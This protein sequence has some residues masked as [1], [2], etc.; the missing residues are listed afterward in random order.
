MN[1]KDAKTPGLK[2]FFFVP[3]GL[4]AFVA[5]KLILYKEKL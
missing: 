3:S 5:M 2:V 4:G 1:H